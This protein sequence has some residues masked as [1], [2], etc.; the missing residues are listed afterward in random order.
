MTALQIIFTEFFDKL[1]RKE[2]I[3]RDLEQLKRWAHANLRKF[4][5]AKCKILHRYRLGGEAALRRMTWGC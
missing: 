3:Q 1:E 2:A 4:S 5:K